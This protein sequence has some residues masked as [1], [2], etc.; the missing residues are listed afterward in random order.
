MKGS[1]A[2]PNA[3]GTI[4]KIVKMDNLARLRLLQSFEQ[5][6][7]ALADNNPQ[8]IAKARAILSCVAG[9]GTAPLLAQ[10]FRGIVKAWDSEDALWR[11]DSAQSEWGGF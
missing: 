7:S 8:A 10:V 11:E 4:G 9:R 3:I 6:S 1:I 2:G 5:L